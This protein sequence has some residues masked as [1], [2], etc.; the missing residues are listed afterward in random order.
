MTA[1]ESINKFEVGATYVGKSHSE[2]DAYYKT[3]NIELVCLDRFEDNSEKYPKTIV[4]M[5]SADGKRKGRYVVWKENDSENC[6]DEYS[7][8][9]PIVTSNYNN[10]TVFSARSKVDFEERRKEELYH[11]NGELRGVL[12]DK[13]RGAP[14]YNHDCNLAS[15]H[16]KTT[17]HKFT[18]GE[19][20]PC[21]VIDGKITEDKSTWRYGYHAK[22]LMAECLRFTGKDVAEFLIID[23]E[24]SRIVTC[25]T[26]Y[27]KWYSVMVATAKPMS[28]EEV[29]LESGFH[30]AERIY[31]DP[32][33]ITS[34]KSD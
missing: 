23:G 31:P 8:D 4:I 33:M 15:F 30:K 34:A 32:L 22:S 26:T 24:D 11:V 12:Y 10:S 6:M 27:Q 16:R 21:Y 17:Y 3:R 28:M 13:L 5:G 29:D 14:Y 25:R 19:L 9:N 20:Y 1:T 2:C 18:V 7:H